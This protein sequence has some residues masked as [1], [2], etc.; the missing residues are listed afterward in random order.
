MFATGKEMRSPSHGRGS[1]VGQRESGCASSFSRCKVLRQSSMVP[2]V[3]NGPN[4][5]LT[6][7]LSTRTG[8]L[9]SEITMSL[10]RPSSAAAI[11][12][13]SSARASE[14]VQSKPGPTART[15]I[16]PESHEL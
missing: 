5:M 3:R 9:Y 15:T 8:R 14:P 12:D 2:V 7:S 4:G 10:S 6:V 16:R 11:A 13:S 1:T